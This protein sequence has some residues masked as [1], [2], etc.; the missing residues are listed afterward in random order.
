MLANLFTLAYRVMRSVV[1]A[2]PTVYVLGNVGSRGFRYSRY[3]AGFTHSDRPFDGSFDAA[4]ADEVNACIE[5][6]DIDM[7]V[8]GDQPTARSLIGLRPSLRARCFPMPDLDTFDLL[9]DKWK[10]FNLCRELDVRVPPTTL[11]SDREVLR[12][13]IDAGDAKLP[14]IAKPLS[15]DGSR[16]V[17]PLLAGGASAALDTIRY[18]P[19]LVQDFIEGVD[20]G[21]SAYCDDGE[22]RTFVLHRLARATYA[23]FANA[24]VFA[25]IARI[26]RETSYTGVFNFDMRLA[27]DGTVYFLECNPRFFYKMSLS[28]LAGVNFVAYGLDPSLPPL[29]VQDT[30]VRTTKAFVATLP[31]PWRLTRRDWASMWHLYSDPLPYLRETLR[32]DWEDRSY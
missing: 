22:V 31:T 14:L 29:F 7:V 13:A 24:T 3:C 8:A 19:V 5:K 28:A 12:L 4:M 23:T 2:G 1:R 32:I 27:P 9:N 30:K 16:G 6:Y 11:Y 15:L 10:F 20:I 26:A 25:S 17:V 18:N 21:A